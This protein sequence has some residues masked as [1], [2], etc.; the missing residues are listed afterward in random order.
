M[1]I[2]LPLKSKSNKI[3]EKITTE[4]QINSIKPTKNLR[5]YQNNF[6]PK[7]NRSASPLNTT[8]TGST[9][10]KRKPESPKPQRVS[11]SKLNMTRMSQNRGRSRIFDSEDDI[12]YPRVSN[13]N[14]SKFGNKMKP[15]K[16]NKEGPGVIQNFLNMTYANLIEVK[17]F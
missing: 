1:P 8:I 16:E 10:R 5:P 17:P 13:N 11:A 14:K 2:R 3:I 15:I 6:K 12:N 4:N 7:R 9:Y